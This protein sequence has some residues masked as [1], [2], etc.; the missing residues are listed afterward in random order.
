MSTSSNSINSYFTSSSVSFSGSLSYYINTTNINENPPNNTFRYGYSGSYTYGTKFGAGVTLT[1]FYYNIFE[2]STLAFEEPPE[3]TAETC[4]V[5]GYVYNEQTSGNEER[6]GQWVYTVYCPID[7]AIT[8]NN[9]DGNIHFNNPQYPYVITKSFPLRSILTYAYSQP[10]GQ[11]IAYKHDTGS[12]SSFMRTCTT[13][14]LESY[15]PSSSGKQRATF[16]VSTPQIRMSASGYDGYTQFKVIIN[17]PSLS[18]INMQ[19]GCL[20]SEADLSCTASG[21]SASSTVYVNYDGDDVLTVTYFE[22]E[23]YAIT[24]GALGTTDDYTLTIYLPQYISSSGTY[25][26]FGPQFNSQTYYCSCTS[27]FKIGNTAYGTN[28]IF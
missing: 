2:S 9:A 3:N 4:T 23:L 27:T 5:F 25:V 26:P 21:N 28:M 24:S 22:I 1:S 8:L 12:V 17:L 16:T 13:A 14:K 7:D 6:D 19:S 15:N 18:N 10:T 11:L 20:I